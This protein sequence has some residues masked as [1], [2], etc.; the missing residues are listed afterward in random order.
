MANKIKGITIEIDANP[1]P[2]N[3][4]LKQID[5]KTRSLSS[6]LKQIN[7]QLKFDPHNAVLLQQKFDV[8][9][10]KVEETRN[11]LQTLKDAQAQ[12]DQQF[13]EGK[14]P[15]EEYRAFQRE[16]ALTESQLKTFEQQTAEAKKDLDNLGHEA[17]ATGK[18]FNELGDDAQKNSK[19]VGDGFNTTAI[20]MSAFTNIV[21]NIGSAIQSA[22][23]HAVNLGKKIGELVKGYLDRADE[24]NTNAKKYG[25]DTATLQKWEYAS[26][27]V[28]VS[29]ETMAKSMAKITRSLNQWRKGNK[30]TIADYEK[31]GVSVTKANGQFRSQEDIFYDVIDALGKMDDEVEADIMSNQIFGRSFQ[32]IEPLVSATSDEIK[33]LG[34]EAEDMGLIMPQE[35]LDNL[36]EA[37]DALDKLEYQMG[38]LLAPVV[39][40]LAPHIESMAKWLSEKLAAPKT[41]EI[42]EKI[43]QAVGKMAEAIT[44]QLIDFI[45]SGQLEELIE[46]IIQA[47]PGITDFI[48]NALPVLLNALV[49]ISGF[50]V[51]I[52]EPMDDFDKKLD[53]LAKKEETFGSK[54]EFAGGLIKRV[55]TGGFDEIGKTIDK[56]MQGAGVDVEGFYKTADK[57]LGLLPGT[58][59]RVFGAMSLDWGDT[60]S[61]M[62]TTFMGWYDKIAEVFGK[63][64]E[65]MQN[66]MSSIPEKI[67]SIFNSAWEKIKEWFD[68]IGEWFRDLPNKIWNWIKSIPEKIAK[69]FTGQATVSA[70][71]K[72]GYH[73]SYAEGGIFKKS[74][75]VNIGEAGPEV[76]LPLNKLGQ[77]LSAVGYSGGGSIVVNAPVQ[78]VKELNDAE[79]NRV[80]GRIT[81][82]VGRQFAKRTGGTL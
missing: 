51:G 46:A 8:L 57:E 45:E 29:T 74:S 65:T 32:E 53:N 37:K 62:W 70:S 42:I 76:V 58:T 9:T 78:V 33:R 13:K 47:L 61:G 43:A 26:E 72:I 28:D 38:V 24:I 12:V 1:T 18:D 23:Q 56:T 50:F 75:F 48:I 11:K 2:L 54:G 27:I 59:E 77:V 7:S 10:K 34:N 3:N 49:E 41:Q 22:I 64:P 55:F 36:N 82:I 17:D 69:A 30:S 4:A 39:E 63:I 66:L 44:T 20:N 31:L 21:R 80:G 16:I 6:E 19:K 52:S 40:A 5:S 67:G 25:I 35:Q 81:D 68:R 73:G 15:E 14:I 60:F 79:L 71:G